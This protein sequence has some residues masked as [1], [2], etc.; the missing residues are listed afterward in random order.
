MNDLR[1]LRKEEDKRLERL[2]GLRRS[3]TKGN[4]VTLKKRI[5]RG[6]I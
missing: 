4:A 1:E 5:Q 3:R 6:E 2:V